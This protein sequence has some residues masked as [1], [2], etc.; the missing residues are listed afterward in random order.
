MN[1]PWQNRYGLLSGNEISR[2]VNGGTIVIEPFNESMIGPNSL[3]VRLGPDLIQLLPYGPWRKVYGLPE[4]HYAEQ[5][6]PWDLTKPIPERNIIRHT[7]PEEGFIL[8]KGVCYLAHTIETIYCTKFVPWLD[9]RSTVGRYFLQCHT[10][11]GR[12]DVG[13]KGTFTMEMISLANDLRVYAGLPIAQVSFFSL[14]GE[15]TP[16]WGRYNGQTGP[17]LPKPLTRP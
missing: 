13:W 11:A 6:E 2:Q 12:G 16:Y 15:I 9:T 17:V 4:E 1:D 10:T 7:I 14:Q 3:D 5:D 8:G